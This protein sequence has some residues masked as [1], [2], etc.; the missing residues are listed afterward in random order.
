MTDDQINAWKV[1][2]DMARAIENEADR[3]KALQTAY[4]HRDEM[5]M[6]CIAHQSG[7]VKAQGKQ[8]EDIMQ[9]HNAMVQSH[10][11]FQAML[12][13]EKHEKEVY[14]KVL[15]VVKWLA[16]LGGGGGIG[17][18]ITKFLGGC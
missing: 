4:D 10:K 6:T 15:A 17:A 5:M 16:A 3:N 14:K 9:H 7:R 18:A 1:E 11:T 2:R 13:Q 12:A 8:I